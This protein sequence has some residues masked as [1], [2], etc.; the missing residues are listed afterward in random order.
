MFFLSVNT[1]VSGG[2]CNVACRLGHELL[3]S[4]GWLMVSIELEQREPGK[5]RTQDELP[6]KVGVCF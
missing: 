4:L 6:E 1:K 2:A 3:A 5:V